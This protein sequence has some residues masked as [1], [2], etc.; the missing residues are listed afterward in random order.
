[1]RLIPPAPPVA[2]SAA[3]TPPDRDKVIDLLRGGS[4]AI[5]VLGHVVMGI[6]V[7]QGDS[8]LIGNTLAAYPWAAYLTW[9]LQIMPLFFAAG[10]AVNRRSYTSSRAAGVA[11]P[12]WLFSRVDRLLTPVL[13]YLAIAA[14]LAGLVSLVL[15]RATT[16]SLLALTTQLLWF[17][18]A[19]LIAVALTPQLVRLCDGHPI[20]GGAGLLGCVVAV[21]V[22]RLQ[23]GLPAVIGLANFVFV[24]AFA[25][26]LG[27][28]L[29]T[30]Q[31]PT[32]VA[33]PML[34]G[35][36]ALNLA[37]TS[38]GIYP[39]SMVGLP[40]E[41]FSNMAPPS[42]VL[43]MHCAVITSAVSLVYPRLTAFAERPKVWRAIVAVNLTAMTLYL[44]HLPVLVTAVWAQHKLGLDRP[45]RLQEPIGPA[46]GAG[47]WLWTILYVTVLLALIAG[48]VRLL[49]PLEHIRVPG[50]SRLPDRGSG[51]PGHPVAMDV[52]AGLGILVIGASLLALAATGLAGFPLRV[53]EYAGVPLNACAAI[54]LVLVGAS[55]VRIAASRT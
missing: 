46:P 31:M 12:R 43:A 49:W 34:L 26:L 18:G 11:Y 25:A 23:I 33:W 38:S 19:Y 55:M 15:P 27:M 41:A 13:V 44:W 24:W 45:A 22:A 6:V 51:S 35:G 16:E 10:G 40:G 42:L 39:I 8:V 7:W 4:L 54:A 52:L 28:L 32:R 20:A 9:G 37:L 48:A 50:W 2:K 5:V 30:G 36:L 14:P 17:I 21:D 29:D 3:A 1:M 53:V 47:F